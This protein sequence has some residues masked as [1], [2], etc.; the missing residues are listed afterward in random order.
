MHDI[1]QG[2]F[3]SVLSIFVL[4]VFMFIFV[5][6]YVVESMK[7]AQEQIKDLPKK[8]NSLS[9]KDDCVITGCSGQICAKE[10]VVT[11]CEYREL[12]DCYNTAVCEAQANG[13]CGWTQTSKLKQCINDNVF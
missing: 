11:S 9:A 4:A 7:D 8:E 13:D 2:K 1:K 10:E 5:L 12:Y 3:F 6:L